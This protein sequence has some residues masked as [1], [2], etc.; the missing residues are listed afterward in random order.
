MGVRNFF[1][2]LHHV[3]RFNPRRRNVF[4]VFIIKVFRC[5]VRVPNYAFVD[6]LVVICRASV[7]INVRARDAFKRD[8]WVANGTIT[9]LNSLAPRVCPF[10]DRVN[11]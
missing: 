2:V 5:F 8:L 4:E 7:V 10:N 1:V 9:N 6:F 3:D 11:R